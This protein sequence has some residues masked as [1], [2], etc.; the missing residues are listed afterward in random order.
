MHQSRLPRQNAEAIEVG[1]AEAAGPAFAVQRDSDCLLL[2]TT[3]RMSVLMLG[4]RAVRSSVPQRAA[5]VA[6]AYTWHPF[7]AP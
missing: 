5:A 4:K 6:K 7:C 2:S 1:A 3:V